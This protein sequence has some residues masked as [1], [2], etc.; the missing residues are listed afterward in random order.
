MYDW[1]D[2]SIPVCDTLNTKEFAHLV[3]CSVKSSRPA[4]MWARGKREN[5][6]AVS[7]NKSSAEGSW[8]KLD[9]SNLNHRLFENQVGE[10]E[11][12]FP[13]VGDLNILWV[14]NLDDSNLG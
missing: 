7:R 4:P 2:D 9:L 10:I 1:S 3:S 6:R 14:N 5:A 8:D 13:A 12:F 11:V